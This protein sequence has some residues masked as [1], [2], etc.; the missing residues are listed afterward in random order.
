MTYKPTPYSE[1]KP[2]SPRYLRGYECESVTLEIANPADPEG[3]FLE[4]EFSL[5]FKVADAEPD[6]GIPDPYIDDWFYAEHDGGILPEPI[7]IAIDK[8]GERDDARN[9]IDLEI[10]DW[11]ERQLEMALMQGGY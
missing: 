6:V 5:F 10:E 9:A 2:F 3:E 4:H 11:H 7:W 8:I 1:A